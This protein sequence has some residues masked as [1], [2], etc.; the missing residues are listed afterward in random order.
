MTQD[1]RDNNSY[2]I[3]IGKRRLVLTGALLQAIRNMRHVDELFQWLAVSIVQQ[4][5]VQVVQLWVAEVG[6]NGQFSMQ[7]LAL[8]SKDNS[9]P[10]RVAFSK[11]IADLAEGIIVRKSAL[12]PDLLSSIFPY[13]QA[14]LLQRFG[15]YYCSG[16]YLRSNVQAPSSNAPGGTKRKRMEVGALLFYS[17]RPE[18]EL[19]R[20]ISYILQLA[21]QIAETNGLSQSL[22]NALSN[23]PGYHLQLQKNRLPA[24]FKLIPHRKAEAELLTTSNPLAGSVLIADKLARRLYQSIDGHKTLEELRVI[25]LLDSQEV[26]KALRTLLSERRIELFDSNGQPVESS[27]FI[28]EL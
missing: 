4:F 16:E 26:A 15:L 22:T 18:P 6:Y 8:A 12:A 25:T 11:P 17:Y 19:L 21:T 10:Q 27:W 14:N 7:Q 20:S 24:L 23:V 1:G 9:L 2:R 28:N 13:F 3:N 5:G